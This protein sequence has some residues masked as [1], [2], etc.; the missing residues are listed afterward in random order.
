MN[1]L[2]RPDL[3]SLLT[4]SILMAAAAMAG[5]DQ[6]AVWQSPPVTNAAAIPAAHEAEPATADVEARPAAAAADV[7]PGSHFAAAAERPAAV[8]APA[9]KDG[10]PRRSAIRPKADRGATADG[11]EKITFDDL[12]LG[13]QADMVY[14]PWMLESE[15]NGGRAK[16]L[17]GKRVRLTGVMHG[18]VESVKKNKEFVLLRN[19]ECKFGPGGQADHLAKIFMKEGKTVSYTDETVYVEGTLRIKPSMGE[20]GNTWSI[21]EIEGGELK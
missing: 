1:Y 15:S 20:D 3:R 6:P 14:R 12:I 8:E 16:E 4:L 5:C 19:A 9:E 2:P 17:E 10:P 11:V 18:G 13:M 21:Y 7:Q